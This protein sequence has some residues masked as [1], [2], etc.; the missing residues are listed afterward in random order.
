MKRNATYLSHGWFCCAVLVLVQSCGSQPAAESRDPRE[1]LQ[2]YL[3][4]QGGDN[5]SAPLFD[6][7]AGACNHRDQQ[8]YINPN[9]TN[10]APQVRRCARDAM[11][12]GASTTA[13]ITRAFPSV[14]QGCARCFGAAVQCTKD[15]CWFE[16]MLN[17]SS[18]DCTSCSLD[19]CRPGLESCTGVPRTHLPRDR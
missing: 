12:N 6:E 17:D 10:F 11:G 3:Q 5:G 7:T 9:N 1:H 14:S 19:N 15:K 8:D 13:C 18:A 2:V 16:C 4:N